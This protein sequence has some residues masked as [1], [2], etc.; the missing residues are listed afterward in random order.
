MNDYDLNY[1][2]YMMNIPNNMNYPP[3]IQNQYNQNINQTTDPRV[4]FIR[5][6]LFTNQY[7]PYKN[8]LPV[9]PIPQNEQQSLLYQ[10][11]QYKFALKDLNLYLDTNPQDRNMLN[12]YNKYLTIEQQMCNKY[13]EIYGPL[14]TNYL[15]QKNQTWIWN[16]NPWPWEVK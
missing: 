12:L 16:N 15:N 11:M 7:D 5:G 14:T 10:I 1:L 6:N 9:E 2:N 13:E 8:Y 4:G 3:N